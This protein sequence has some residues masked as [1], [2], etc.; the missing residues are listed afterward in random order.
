MET[1]SK[2]SH[3]RDSNRQQSNKSTTKWLIKENKILAQWPSQ[4]LNLKMIEVLW[5]DLKKAMQKQISANLNELK[6]SW[7][8]R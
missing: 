6:Q 3:Q 4:S 7:K 2:L 5:W 8:E 1:W